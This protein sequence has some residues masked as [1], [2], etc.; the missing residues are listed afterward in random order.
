MIF[1]IFLLRFLDF[2]LDDAIAGLSSGGKKLYVK[3]TYTGDSGNTGLSASSYLIINIIINADNT[4]HNYN[5]YTYQGYWYTD[6]YATVY[7]F[8]ID[9]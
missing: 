8:Y 6:S 1:L 5:F 7:I 9:K 4:V 2:Q 3:S